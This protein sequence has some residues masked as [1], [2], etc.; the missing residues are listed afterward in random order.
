M[1]NITI[2]RLNTTL[3]TANITAINN[4]LNAIVAV[5]PAGT[6]TDEERNTYASIEVDNK[7]FT[8]DCV[9][10]LA[11][12]GA[13]IMPS[14]INV[15]NLITDFTLFEQLDSIKSGIMLA[16]RRVE[17]LQRIA[18]KEAYEVATKVYQ[19]YAAAS[20]AGIPDAKE[21]Y[22]KLRTRYA[23]NGRPKEDPIK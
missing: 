8:E 14:Y 16:L 4:A 11:R 9:T 17:D 12:N 6:L 13:A 22:E 23:G 3:T 15:P 1:A 7:I 21:S 10:E 2:N 18:G 5:L 20:D 19:Q